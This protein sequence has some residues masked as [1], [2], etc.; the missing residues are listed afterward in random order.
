MPLRKHLCTWV[1]LVLYLALP[2]QI[3]RAATVRA[4]DPGPGTLALDSPWQF[5]T[6]DDPRWSDPQYDD[7][8]WTALKPTDTWGSQGFPAYTGYAWYRLRLSLVG[9]AST[10]SLFIPAVDDNYAVYWNGACVG[11]FGG[12]PPNAVLFNAPHGAIFDLPLV[13]RTTPHVQLPSSLGPAADDVSNGTIA[14]RVWKSQLSSLDPNTLGGFEEAPVLGARS[15]L[16]NLLEA[17]EA[18]HDHIFR[19]REMF[20]SV[21]LAFGLVSLLLFFRGARAPI[22]LWLAVYLVVD[23]ASAIQ[24]NLLWYRARLVPEQIINAARASASHF[25]V[26]AILLLLFGMGR[27]RRWQRITAVVIGIDVLAEIADSIVLAFWQF[28]SPALRWADGIT[29]ALY[30]ILPAYVFVIIFAGLRRGRQHRLWPVILATSAHSLYNL[31]VDLTT[32]GIRFTGVTLGARLDAFTVSVAGYPIGLR[33]LFDFI[34]LVALVWTV[35][36]QQARERRRRS[37]LELE[38]KSAQEIQ[39]VLV[40]DALPELPG[41]AVT[42][43]YR[44]AQEV[45]GDFFQII[46]TAGR[47]I[48]LIIGDVSGKGLKA[49]MTV[50]LIVGALRT[51]AESTLAPTAILD[52]LNRR[53]LGRTSGGF[54]TCL[55]LHIAEDGDSTLANAGHIPPFRNG[56]ELLLVGSVPLGLVDD[57]V[58]EQTT[59]HLA[60]GDRLTVFTDGLPEARDFTGQLFGFSRVEHLLGSSSGFDELIE[61]ACRFGQEDDI[62]LLSLTRV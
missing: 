44:P 48:L 21:V 16:Q 7:S 27:D 25:A 17:R 8:G 32:Q 55:V 29:S 28:P 56:A 52:G 43:A 3:I 15:T 30:T 2:Q 39:R 13:P 22:L 38:I 14:I 31:L 5:H 62:T 12:F 18:A 59:F 47:G 41:F 1:L 9:S 35:A 51:L 50:S 10:I 53:L 54:V 11:T 61:E 46:P 49:A 45:G 37:F 36:Q 19:A 33:T 24:I 57:V 60:P 42:A 34:F 4:V 58:Y 40:P 23:A 20:S 6:G 26:Y